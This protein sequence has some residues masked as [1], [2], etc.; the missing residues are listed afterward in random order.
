[1]SETYLFG[2]LTAANQTTDQNGRELP[3]AQPDQRPLRISVFQG[4]GRFFQRIQNQ[5]GGKGFA[6]EMGESAMVIGVGRWFAYR[7]DRFD[8]RD[9]QIGADLHGR[10]RY[11]LSILVGHLGHKC[12]GAGVEGRTRRG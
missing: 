8:R 3:K 10:R 11:Q 6:Q 12:G 5:T 2:L 9:R 1:M 4:K 7:A